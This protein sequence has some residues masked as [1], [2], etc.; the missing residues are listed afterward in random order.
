MSSHGPVFFN[1]VKTERVS[2]PLEVGCSEAQNC[3]CPKA[4]VKQIN[5]VDSTS[6]FST[7][8]HLLFFSMAGVNFSVD[9]EC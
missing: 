7:K 5:T 2:Q 1:L 4:A 9:Q 8:I 6:L 3:F